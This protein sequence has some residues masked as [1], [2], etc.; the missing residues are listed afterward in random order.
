MQTESSFTRQREVAGRWLG[1]AIGSLIIA[2]VFAILVVVARM[3]PFSDYITDPLF[4]RRCLAIHVDLALVVWFFAFLASLFA[5]LPTHK[6]GG[7]VAR[8]S[9][10]VGLAG[11][12]MLITAAVQPHAQPVL[13]NYIPMVDHPV[14]ISGL[15]LF[16]IGVLMSFFDDRMLPG[17][18][19]ELGI[20]EVP[21]AARP[22]IRAAAVAF[23]FAMLTF[24]A[25]VLGTPSHLGPELYYEFVAWGGGHVLQFASVAAMIGVWLILLN[26]VLPDPVMSR[27]T[28]TVLHGLL[29][30]PI[31]F[32][33]LL[34]IEDTTTVFYHQIFT[35]LME[36]GIFPVTLV[37][38]ALVIRAV[39][40]AYRAGSLV[41]GLTSPWLLAVATSIVM[42]LIGFMLGA[43]I[44]G[45][46]TVVPA[47]YHASIGAVTVAYMALTWPILQALGAPISSPRLRKALQWQPLLYGAGQTVFA[48][49]FGLAGANGMGRKLFG[50]EQHVRTLEESA[51][52]VIMGV[53]G[54]V[55]IAAGLLFIVSVAAVWLRAQPSERGEVWSLRRSTSSRS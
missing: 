17:R 52:L 10:F 3:P 15:V 42:T 12:G 34:A 6:G 19:T 1:L 45:S 54:F 40:K 7:P 28:S 36:L 53:G 49:G 55:A 39:W 47:H 25:A 24:L 46:N 32:A 30:L 44:S 26:K 51:G 22:A 11:V 13:S 41:G 16:G 31:S 9:P 50:A 5:L 38:V 35:R 18:E 2:G 14:F 8:L 37:V 27:R 4:F 21:E 23:L 29:I 48:V 33:P 20:V 43:F